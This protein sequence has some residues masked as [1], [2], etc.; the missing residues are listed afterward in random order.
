MIRLGP[1]GLPTTLPK[2]RKNTL[3]GIKEVKNLGL[4]AM[5]IEFVRNI[6]L[7][8]KQAKE[9]GKLAKELD[10]MLSVHAPYY[11]N[12]LSEKE[13][14]VKKSKFYILKSLE[15]AEIMNAKY[16]VVHAA[17]YGKLTKE[18]AFEKMIEITQE[19]LDEMKKRKIR[20]SILLYETMAKT[21]QFADFNT[22]LEFRDRIKNKNFGICI[23]FA[24][25]FAYNDGKIDYN[26]IFDLAKFDYYHTHFSNVKFNLKT[27]K[28]IDEH[29]PIN[30]HPSFKELAKV[31]V[32]RKIENITIISESP[33]LEQDS[34]K[35]KRILESLGYRF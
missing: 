27:K 16:V 30:S 24:H 15:I 31:L 5:E 34:L 13:E 21:S 29:E 12:L 26:E 8:E 2:E 14:T 23:D 33:I 6:Y 4:S 32:D 35:M 1:A 3:E 17:Y 18:E 19:I 11:I 20:N 28:F 25:I 22:L 7:N 9:V 10:V